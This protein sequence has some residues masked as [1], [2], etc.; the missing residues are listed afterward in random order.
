MS[1]TNDRPPF[2]GK[3]SSSAKENFPMIAVPREWFSRFTETVERLTEIAE[4]AVGGKQAEVKE[5]R[6]LN[7]EE[8]SKI[9]HVHVQT[10]TA[11]CREGKKIKGIKVGGNETNGRGGKWL[12]P[13]E[14]IERY[15]HRQQVIYGKGK[16]GGK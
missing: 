2:P 9:M 7:P 13:L 15:L 4:R 8:A 6:L 12:I 3:A 5:K 11:W 10:I 14:E 16:G 1:D